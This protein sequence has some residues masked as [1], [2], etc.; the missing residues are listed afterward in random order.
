MV[1]EIVDPEMAKEVSG[2]GG[3]RTPASTA[4]VLCKPS[5]GGR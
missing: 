3:R 2:L 5:R 1:F 4:G